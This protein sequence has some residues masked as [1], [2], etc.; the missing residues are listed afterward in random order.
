MVHL[1]VRWKDDVFQ[2]QMSVFLS[3]V[4]TADSELGRNWSARSVNIYYLKA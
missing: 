1:F 2:L 3:A 4:F